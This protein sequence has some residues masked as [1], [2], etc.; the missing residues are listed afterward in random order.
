MALTD[1][2][3]GIANRRALY[4]ALDEMFVDR[5]VGGRKVPR[6]F[7]LAL[8]DLDHFK[9]VNDSFGHAVGDELLQAVVR[10]FA[11]ALET[12]QTPH[13]LARL[14]GDEFAVIL[15]DAG[16]YNAAMACASAL[17]ESLNEPI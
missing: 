13:L 7:A 16:S 14:G 3:T 11:G 2:L 1:E 17:Q 10:R 12:L 8:I 15:H 9:E 4:T 6:E 5:A